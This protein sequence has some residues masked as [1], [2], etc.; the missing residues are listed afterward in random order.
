MRRETI[1][2]LDD[3]IIHLEYKQVKNINMRLKDSEGHIYVSAPNHVSIDEIKAIVLKKRIAINNSISRM[4]EVAKDISTS[5]YE[6]GDSIRFMGEDYTLAVHLVMNRRLRHIEIDYNTKILKMESWANATCD[7]RHQQ[8]LNFYKVQLSDLL[9]ELLDKWKSQ[10]GVT[11]SKVQVRRM[12][13]RW[14]SCSSAGHLSFN[15]ALVKLPYD[16]VELIVVHELTHRIEMNHG[17]HF[18]AIMNKY[19]PNCKELNKQL[20]TVSTKV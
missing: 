1:L 15:L 18:Y 16:L 6:S 5:N 12:K 7:I 10:L 3:L 2:N 9:N 19:L 11:I 17:T 8:L 20:K 14:G 13:T 4:K